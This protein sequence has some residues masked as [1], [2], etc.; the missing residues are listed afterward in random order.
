MNNN[1][2][3]GITTTGIVPHH[4]L[5]YGGRQPTVVKK[6][7]LPGVEVRILRSVPVMS[8]ILPTRL[9]LGRPFFRDILLLL[10]MPVVAGLVWN[11]SGL[12]LVVVSTNVVLDATF[13]M[14]S[15]P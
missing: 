1:N 15:V 9:G 2:N 3:D 8:N 10:R 12:V 4:P 13:R 14:R 11:T 5:C 6:L 7:P